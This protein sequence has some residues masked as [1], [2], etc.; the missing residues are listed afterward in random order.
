LPPVGIVL[1][2]PRRALP[3]AAVFRARSG[4]FG[5]GAE[6]FRPTPPDAGALAAALADCRNDLTEAAVALVPEIAE[7]LAALARLPGVLIARMSGSG[8]TC[9]ALFADLAAAASAGALLAT[10]RPRWWCAACGLVAETGI[11]R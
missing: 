11:S 10:A 9:F 4:P 8:A 3:T 5:A 1:A 2:N 7:V 6:R